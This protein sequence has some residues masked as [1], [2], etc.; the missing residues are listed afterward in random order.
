LAVVELGDAVPA[1]GQVTNLRPGRYARLTVE[2]TGCGMDRA[3]M[4]RI[5][6]PFFTT[7]AVGKGTG[8]GLSVIHGIITKHGGAIDVRSEVGKG[9]TFD[10]YLPLHD[11]AAPALPAGE[12]DGDGL[13]RVALTG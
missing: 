4:A 10:V 13:A 1:S 7:K 12:A 6:E 2:D 11:R 3:T 9:T 8:L 5:F